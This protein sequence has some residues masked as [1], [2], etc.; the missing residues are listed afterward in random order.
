VAEMRHIDPSYFTCSTH[1]ER[2]RREGGMQFEAPSRCKTDETPKDIATGQQSILQQATGIVLGGG[3][4]KQRGSSV[5]HA[6]EVHA[7][8]STARGKGAGYR[9]I[10]PGK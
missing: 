5:S 9:I 1:T 2:G 4:K 8:P 3:E 6:K 7:E 10:A